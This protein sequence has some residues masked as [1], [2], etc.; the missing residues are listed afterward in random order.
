MPSAASRERAAQVPR[1]GERSAGSSRRRGP[2]RPRAG[3]RLV[4]WA[5]SYGFLP[6]I[7]PRAPATPPHAHHGHRAF[8]P[9]HRFPSLNSGQA[10][11]LH[12][13]RQSYTEALKENSTLRSQI[14]PISSQFTRFSP[15]LHGPARGRG[16][17]AGVASPRPMRKTCQK[18]SFARL[19]IALA[20]M[21][22]AA[23]TIVAGAQADPINDTGTPSLPAFEGAP[24]TAN[25]ITP[26]KPPQ[27]PYMAANP[28]SNIH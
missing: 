7:S 19:K 18:L 13:W 6:P 2:R 26:T 4:R 3:S 24:A 8:R 11:G 12:P 23:L 17:I 25:K 9:N 5:A 28:N 14:P 20:L 22:A 1:R 16:R 10:H 27:N 21:A 15:S